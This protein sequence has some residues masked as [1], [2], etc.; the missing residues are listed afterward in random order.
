MMSSYRTE[1]GYPFTAMGWSY[2]WD[3]AAKT[4]MGVSEYVLRR[5]TVVHDATWVSPAQFCS[6][7]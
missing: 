6:A 4:P 7:W 5:R 1:K 2:N 3:P